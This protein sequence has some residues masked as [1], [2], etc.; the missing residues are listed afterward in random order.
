MISAI[1]QFTI[2]IAVASRSSVIAGSSNKILQHQN[3]NIRGTDTD[4][5]VSDSTISLPTMLT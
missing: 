1:H 4:D 5:T 3:Q 2:A